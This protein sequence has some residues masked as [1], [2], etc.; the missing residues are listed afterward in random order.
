MYIC[1]QRLLHIFVVRES[2][3]SLYLRKRFLRVVMYHIYKRIQQTCSNIDDATISKFVMD[4]EIFLGTWHESMAQLLSDGVPP[5][6]LPAKG[7]SDVVYI[8]DYSR[9]RIKDGNCLPKWTYDPTL[10]RLSDISSEAVT[11]F[12]PGGDRGDC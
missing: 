3:H 8:W 9:Q 1:Q 11:Y 7:V 6:K 4:W 2:Q 12:S 5:R 10:D